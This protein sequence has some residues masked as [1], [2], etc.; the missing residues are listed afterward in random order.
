MDRLVD[1][2]HGFRGV[3]STILDQADLTGR[4]HR[5]LINPHRTGGGSGQRTIEQG[6]CPRAG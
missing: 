4:W 1:T 5:A 3:V 2:V 6:S